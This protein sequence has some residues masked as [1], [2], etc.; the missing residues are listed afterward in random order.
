[1]VGKPKTIVRGRPMTPEEEAAYVREVAEQKTAALRMSLDAVERQGMPFVGEEGDA[2]ARPVVGS[3]TAGAARDPSRM[4]DWPRVRAVGGERDVPA[5]DPIARDYLLLALRL[6]QRI[7]GLVDGYFGPAD[8]KAQVDMEQLRRPD[9]LVADAADLTGPARRRGRRSRPAGLA[10]ASSSS[11]L[12]TQA[13]ALAGDRAAVRRARHALLRL[14]R[15]S[16]AT[17]PYSGPRPRASTGSSRAR[18]RCPSGSRPGTT[19]SVVPG[20]RLPGVIDWLAGRRSAPGRPSCSGCRTVSRSGCPRDRT[21]RGPATTGTTAGSV[22]GSTS[23]RTC[24]SGRRSS[25][26]LVAHETY[27]GHHLEHAWKEADLV[28]ERRPAR[29]ERPADQRSRVLHQRGPGRARPAVRGP[30]PS[31]RPTCSSSSSTG[32]ACA[33]ADDDATA[34]TLD[35]RAGGRDRATR[36]GAAAESAVNAALMRHVDG[37]AHDDGPR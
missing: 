17:R 4:T 14:R 10:R 6:D 28:D 27:P 7:P 19:G 21:S 24:P 31:R 1:M 9:R 26:D 15:P 11:A 5:P 20:E 35:G 34:A 29:G 2:G 37:A 25:V 3:R 16:D 30:P 8:L 32:P 18:G 23:T 12:E 33:F 36:R 22:R 13:R